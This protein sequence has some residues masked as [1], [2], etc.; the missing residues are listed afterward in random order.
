MPSLASLQNHLSH[1]LQVTSATEVVLFE[2]TTFL[3][4]SSVTA[5]GEQSSI[6]ASAAGT[7]AP[8]SGKEEAVDSDWDTRRFERISTMVKAFKL[9]CS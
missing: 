7:K 9:G 2:K 8:E 4:I 5:T 6:A 1:F 3:V